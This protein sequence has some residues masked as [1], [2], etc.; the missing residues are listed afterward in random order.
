M[1]FFRCVQRFDPGFGFNGPYAIQPLYSPAVNYNTEFPQLGSGHLVQTP[2]DHQ[3][4]PIPSHLLGPR[5][6]PA[7]PS[8]VKYGPPEGMM[9]PYSSNPARGHST[10][11][12]YMNSSQYSVPPTHPGMS[13]PHPNGPIQTFTQVLFDLPFSSF[14]LYFF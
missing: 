11:P 3:R 4:G 10:A 9:P 13:F 14:H 7:V 2:L 5:L 8:V 12:L 6:S 1:S